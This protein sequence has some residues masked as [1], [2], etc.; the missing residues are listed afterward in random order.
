MRLRIVRWLYRRLG[1][2][3][4][5]LLAAAEGTGSV[6]VAVATV[7]LAATYFDPTIPRALL[8]A[9]IG[10]VTTGTSVA[11]AAYAQRST[12]TQFQ[13]W[14]ADPE[15]AP[16]QTVE[17]WHTI[18][19]HTWRNFRARAGKINAAAVLPATAVAAWLWHI[20]WTGWL[21]LVLACVVPIGY[22]LVVSYSVGELLAIP[23]AEEVAAQ[24]PDDFALEPGLL[25]VAKRLKIALPAYTS[26][27]AMVGI[28]LIDHR[29]G[30]GALALAATASLV[31]G[32]GLSTELTVLLG[33][34]VTGPV[35][36]VREQVARVR[37]GD[38]TART[39]VLSSDELGQLTHDVNVMASGLAER[40][41][42]REAFGT[43]MDK[44]VVEV[45]LSGRF[46]PEG[47]E[48]DVSI[49]F[50]DVRG[51]T[52]Y[53]EGA[54]APEVISTLNAMFAAIVPIV[55]K[56]HGHVD[57][58]L[59]DGML[60]VFGAPELLPDHADCAVAAACE[61]VE[62]VSLG[63]SGLTLGAGVNTGRVVA[64][65]IGGAGRLN[66]SVIGDAVNV[67]ARVEAATR[68]TG[69]DVLLTDA[70]RRALHRP[71]AVVSRGAVE[72]KGKSAPLELFA[73]VP[74]PA[75]PVDA[76]AQTVGRER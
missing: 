24:L 26:T 53:A 9:G 54:S 11:T 4:W 27:A 15:P 20:G 60:A 67:A 55:E 28:S 61:I 47:V 14:R 70:T 62:A 41:E 2:H 12:Y 58:F 34:A 68:A 49:L 29:N 37:A 42:I 5:V 51:F 56:H 38:F 36:R 1:R 44:S 18:I 59:G 64:G 69:D 63:T 66:F 23:L 74:T 13:A 35:E 57:K 33:D 32:I 71:L 43:Y 52:A 45:I 22:S 25:P 30:A 72:L 48:L 6:L 46:P 75:V 50:C 76:S 19:T 16:E 7:L 10:A 17:L 21:A 65:P 31:I 3:S 39:P 40:E 73:P 8:A